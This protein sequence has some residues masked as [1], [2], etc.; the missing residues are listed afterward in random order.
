MGPE[1]SQHPNGSLYIRVA[2]FFAQP[3]CL[4]LEGRSVSCAFSTSC[5][6][7]CPFLRLLLLGLLV[8]F[9][10]SRRALVRIAC[11][12]CCC[13]A[14]Q[15]TPQAAATAVQNRLAVATG[16]RPLG[17]RNTDRDRDRLVLRFATGRERRMLLLLTPA[18]R[19]VDC[20]RCLF[21][22]EKPPY[23]LPASVT[24]INHRFYNTFKVLNAT[25]W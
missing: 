9:S 2:L 19:I 8:E 14:A 20:S 5:S 12:R 17:G 24:N 10:G 25:G 1:V 16:G 7:P 13:L 15:D 21:A 6:S 11:C 4:S 3:C 22:A 23:P 18:L